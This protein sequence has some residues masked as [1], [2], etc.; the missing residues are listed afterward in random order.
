M[1]RSDPDRY[2]NETADLAVCPTCLAEK[3]ISMTVAAIVEGQEVRFCRCP[4]C[5]DLFQKTPQVFIERLSGRGS[6]PVGPHC[7]AT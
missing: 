7:C 6:F 3:P 4:G 1:F 5:R 2:V